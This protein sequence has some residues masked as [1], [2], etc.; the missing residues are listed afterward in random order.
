[1]SCIVCGKEAKRSVG[2]FP[3]CRGNECFKALKRG[4]HL[5]TEEAEKKP[6]KKKEVPVVEEAVVEH[7]TQAET[8]VGERS[9][10]GNPRD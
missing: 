5:K 4:D 9:V 1:M 10:E 7:F 8:E 2:D 3:L 6:R